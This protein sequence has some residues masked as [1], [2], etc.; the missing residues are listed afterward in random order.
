MDKTYI[1]LNM[2]NTLTIL[3]MASAGALVLGLIAA[4]LQ[5]FFPGD[6]GSQDEVT[7][8]GTR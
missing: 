1:Q 7:A 3:L 5:T 8:Q 6:D 4:G 2:P